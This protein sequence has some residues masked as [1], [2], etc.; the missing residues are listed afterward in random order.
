MERPFIRNVWE[1]NLEEEINLMSKLVD[2][3]P[4]IAFDT[5]FPGTLVRCDSQHRGVFAEALFIARWTRP[6]RANTKR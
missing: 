3:Y 2:I 6:K 4:Y 1:V 5:E